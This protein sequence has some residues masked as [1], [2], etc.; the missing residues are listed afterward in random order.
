[1]DA[2]PDVLADQA[3]LQRSLT[4]ANHWFT[5]VTGWRSDGPSAWEG[6]PFI[7]AAID[8]S[9]SSART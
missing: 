4:V 7:A 8:V 9:P 2:P 3:L 5:A 6:W 1:M